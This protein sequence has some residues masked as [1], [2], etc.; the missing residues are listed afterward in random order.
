MPLLL[1]AVGKLLFAILFL[2]RVPEHKNL[3]HPQHMPKGY[4]VP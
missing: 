2:L 3:R 4:S 1:G